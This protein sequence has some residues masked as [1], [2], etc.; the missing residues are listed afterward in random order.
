M[1]YSINLQ[2]SRGDKQAPKNEKKWEWEKL[3][4]TLEEL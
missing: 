4:N 3:Q 2:I 1:G